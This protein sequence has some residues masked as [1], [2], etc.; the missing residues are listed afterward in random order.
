MQAAVEAAWLELTLGAAPDPDDAASIDAWLRRQELPETEWEHL[1]TELPRLLIYRELVQQTL[2]DAIELTIPRC[3]ARLGEHFERYFS[4]FLSEVGPR[5]PYL[6][7][8]AFDF[9]A[10]LAPRLRAA[11]ELPH[12]LA[13]LARHEA[14]QIELAALPSA[15][16][17]SDFAAPS[18]DAPLNVLAPLRLMH[19]EHAV[20]R[21]SEDLADRTPAS[22][23]P[24][25]VLAYRSAEHDVRYLELSALAA[26]LLEQIL[27]GASLRDA[28]RLST[29]KLGLSLDDEVLRGSATLLSDLCER[30]VLSGPP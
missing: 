17:P 18:L 24:T 5:S 21:L 15:A 2:R 22:P 4:A 7:E 28:L 14:L 27:A 23:E 12:Y 9:V 1:R 6:R 26:A 11:A 29:A 16:S 20:H 3:M 10:Y 8:V 13:D 19:Y 25:H 30:G